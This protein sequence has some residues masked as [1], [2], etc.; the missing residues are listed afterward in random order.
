VKRDLIS[1][2]RTM[3]ETALL[4]GYVLQQAARGSYPRT[5]RPKTGWEWAA[6]L[7]VS[8]RC[9]LEF[10]GAQRRHATSQAY[11]PPAS[12]LVQRFDRRTF[13][14]RMLAP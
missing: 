14:D 10:A 9:V 6:L 13:I 1:V 2:T 5:Q 7:T 11:A 3:V 8:D 12:D 4:A